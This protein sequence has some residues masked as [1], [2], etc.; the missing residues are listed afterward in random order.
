MKINRLKQFLLGTLLIVSIVTC[1]KKES[2]QEE[3]VRPIKTQIIGNEEI[4]IGYTASAEIKGKEEIPYV[5]TSQGTVTVVNAKNGDQVNAGQLI[6]A[7]DNQTARSSAVAANSNYQ[8]ARINYEKYAMLYNE[9]L[10]TETEYLQAKTNYDSAR[11]NLQIASDASA[12]TSIRTAVPGVIADLNIKEHQEVTAGVSLFTLVDDSEM[13]IE[14]G[15]PAATVSKINI[16]STAKIKIDEIQKEVE[17]KVTE[18]SGAADKITR[19]FLV[20]IRISNQNKELKKGMYGTVSINTGIEQGIIVPKEAIVIR[21]IEKVIYIVENGKSKA[22][23]VKI[24]NQNEKYASIEATGIKKGMEI[25]IEGQNV[26]Q[27][28]EKIKKIN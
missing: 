25:I 9:R 19:Q 18:I 17:G 14:V 2:I 8:A 27:D 7:I 6:I 21:G 4:S 22:I 3:T 11:A 12:K 1:G 10:V 5:A 24:T 23:V 26:I 13:Q 20:K 28:G 15:V 16:G